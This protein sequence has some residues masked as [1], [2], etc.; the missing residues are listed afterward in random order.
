MVVAL[1]YEGSFQ[2]YGTSLL[3]LK[4]FVFSGVAEDVRE[5]ICSI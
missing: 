4:G 2:G 3:F 1:E 5:A